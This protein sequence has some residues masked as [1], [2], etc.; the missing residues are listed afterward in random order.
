MATQF[1]QFTHF[2]RKDYQ[3]FRSH[4]PKIPRL[5]EDDLIISD[6]KFS[7]TIE[8]MVEKFKKTQNHPI[9]PK[10]MGIMMY[11][12]GLNDLYEPSIFQA[13]ERH[14]D[15]YRGK[16]GSRLA[17]GCLYGLFRTNAGTSKGIEFFKQE[18]LDNFDDISAREAFQ[19][20]EGLSY[21]KQLTTEEIHAMMDEVIKPKLLQHWHKTLQHQ[22]KKMIRL[23]DFLIAMDYYDAEIWEHLL[24]ALRSR[25]SLQGV[26]A[27]SKLYETF[28]KLNEEGKVPFDLSEDVEHY[29]NILTTKPDNIWRYNVEEKRFYTY[30]ELKAKR[31]DYPYPDQIIAPKWGKQLREEVLALKDK[32]YI[33]DE[34]QGL[35]YDRNSFEVLLQERFDMVKRGNV[36]ELDD[37]DTFRDSLEELGAERAEGEE[38][39]ESQAEKEAEEEVT[40]ELFGLDELQKKAKQEADQERLQ[41]KQK[42]A[43]KQN[44]NKGKKN[45]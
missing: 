35:D 18:V 30:Q 23:V 8:D 16:F 3:G 13:F 44:Q 34:E 2:T 4:I 36:S 43:N 27:A 29:K 26:D 5:A 1:N 12:C 17:F 33:E 19:L 28:S 11:H 7:E 25:K 10:N 22:K 38:A 14:M 6:S 41:Q 15:L 20:T 42:E 9:H 37:A 32:P 24:V 39:L 40:E 21:N 31:N 45:K